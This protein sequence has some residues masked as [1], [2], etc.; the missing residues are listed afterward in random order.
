MISKVIDFDSDPNKKLD[1]KYFITIEESGELNPGDTVL[2]RLKTYE[3]GYW[4]VVEKNIVSG[5]TLTPMLCA[6]DSAKSVEE[7]GISPWE[8]RYLYLLEHLKYK[9]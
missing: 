5:K 7:M 1:S 2:V 4:K 8:E 6:L 3:K 9:R